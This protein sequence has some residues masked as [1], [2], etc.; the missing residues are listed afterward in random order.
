MEHSVLIACVV[1]TSFF[2]IFF[3][4]SVALGRERIKY[5]YRGMTTNTGI[6]SSTQVPW[7]QIT[8]RI[9]EPATMAAVRREPVGWRRGKYGTLRQ[10]A[11]RVAFRL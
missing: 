5:T 4:G 2:W 8:Q 10:F 11:R 3:G 7:V 6:G 1:S 9:A